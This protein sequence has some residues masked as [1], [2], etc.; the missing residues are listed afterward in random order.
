[1]DVRPRG[2]VRLAFRVGAEATIDADRLRSAPLA[3][4]TARSPD[5][6]V[7]RER[8]AVGLAVKTLDADGAVVAALGVLDLG[9]ARSRRTAARGSC[10]G[11]RRGRS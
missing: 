10:C 1:M 6:R 4:G 11:V 9:G 7:Q 8:L 5:V 2:W 3:T